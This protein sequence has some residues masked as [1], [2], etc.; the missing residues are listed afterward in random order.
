[1]AKEGWDLHQL[2]ATTGSTRGG[3]DEPKEYAILVFQQDR[4]NEEGA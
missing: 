4:E 3:Y 1:M 2:S